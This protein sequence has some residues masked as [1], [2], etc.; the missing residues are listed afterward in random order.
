MYLEILARKSLIFYMNSLETLIM[1]ISSKT[2]NVVVNSIIL[3]LIVLVFSIVNTYAYN[4]RS[5]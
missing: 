3:K 5:S 1:V 2:L 4:F